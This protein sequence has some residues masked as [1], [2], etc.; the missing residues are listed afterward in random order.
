MTAYG[1]TS[2]PTGRYRRSGLAQRARRTVL[3]Q[4][5]LTAALCLCG[6]L[7]LW[8]APSKALAQPDNP[9]FVDQ[10]PRAWELLCRARDQAP[11]NPGE[12]VRLYQELLDDYSLK[13]VPAD[14]SQQDRFVATRGPVLSDLSSNP[15]LLQRYRAMEKAEAQ[16]MLEAGELERLAIT[17]S[18]TE[19]G[20]E[21]LLRLAQEDLE[22]AR[23]HSANRRLAEALAHP[24]LIGRRAAHAWYMVGLAAHC[25]ADLTRTK[26]AL[27]ALTDLDDAG[28]QLHGQLQ[29][30]CQKPIASRIAEGASSVQPEATIEPGEPVGQAIWTVELTDALQQRLSAGPTGTAFSTGLAPGQV[31]GELLTAS[32]TV[33]GSLAYINQG[34]TILALDRSTGREAWRHVDRP[35]S[36]VIDRDTE[37]VMDVN[38]IAVSGGSLVTLTGHAYG[39]LRSSEGHVLCLDSATGDVRWATILNRIGGIDDHEGL[40]PHGAPIIAEGIVYLAARKV[41]EQHLS[42]CYVVALDL[43]DGRLRWS[44]H[45]ASAGGLRARTY[46]RFSLLTF[47]RGDLYVATPLGAVAR[48]DGS[49]GRMQWLQRYRVPLN[50]DIPLNV[51]GPWTSPA[52][53]VTA[54][55]VIAIRPDGQ[56]VVVLER[57]TG[58]QVASHP[59][60]PRGTWASPDYLLADDR[61]IFAIGDELRAFD[62]DNLAEPVWRLP[63]P[64]R[65][66]AVAGGTQIGGFVIAGRHQLTHRDLVVPTDRGILLVDKATGQVRHHIA[67]PAA[68]NPLA[69]EGQIILAGADRLQAYMSFERASA[70]LRRR[71]SESPDDPDAALAL[72]ELSMASGDLTV[73]MEAAHIATEAIRS[74]DE[75]AEAAQVQATL[76]NL[77]LRF[78]RRELERSSP[79][80]R[81]LHDLLG[82]VAATDEQRVEHLLAH[83]DWL[84]TS[85]PPQAVERYQQIISD[86]HLALVWRMEDG[87]LQTAAAW[88]ARRIASLVQIHGATIQ[89]PQ[90]RNARQ[91]LD[92]VLA[93]TPG[94]LDALRGIS[95]QY[96]CTDAA[97]EAA[98][99]ASNAHAEQ[100]EHRSTL[101]VLSAL[102]DLVPNRDAPTASRLLGAYLSTCRQFGLN[103]EARLLLRQAVQSLNDPILTG[104]FDAARASD[105]LREFERSHAPQRLPHVGAQQGLGIAI[106][107][108]LVPRHP[109]APA[110]SPPDRALLASDGTVRLVTSASLTGQWSNFIDS[111]SPQVLRFTDR[112]VLLWL[113][114]DPQDPRAVML[115]A[116]DG[117]QRWT[118]PRLSDHLDDPVGDLARLRGT[119]DQMPNGDPF[120]P[121]EIIPS[122]NDDLLVLIRRTG[123]AIA[124]DLRE[125]SAPLWAQTRVLDQVYWTDLQD[126]TLVMAGRARS[127]DSTAGRGELKPT[128]VVL[129][130]LT[131]RIIHRAEPRGESDVLWMCFGPLGAL[132]YATSQ[133]IES[134]DLNSG[135][136][137]WMNVQPAALNT[138]RAWSAGGLVFFQDAVSSLR[139]LASGQPLVSDPLPTPQHGQ[140]DPLELQT[141]QIDRGRVA[142]LYAQRVVMYDEQGSVT[143][144][145]YITDERNY[146]WLLP[147]EDRL[148]LV[149]R[150]RTEQVE[151]PDDTG[152][153]TLRTYRVYALSGNGR[154]LG[155]ATE[156]QPLPRR[157]LDAVLIDDWL[158]LS[159][160]SETIAFPLPRDR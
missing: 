102:I 59:C 68:G 110:A 159:T 16:R 19:P 9:I 55:H 33:A 42:S 86:R 52:P 71:L 130:A 66:T 58:R 127:A 97:V 32:P 49:T 137:R 3:K 26:D 132:S 73:T 96:H 51:P 23:F 76:F 57:D 103:E 36:S 152:R 90:E 153:R 38:Y 138:T 75:A 41:T 105:L 125:G 111:D 80:I 37:L 121:D 18:L 119:W 40:F 72:M 8:I 21:A 82:L 98:I 64:D 69:I 45:I 120:N 84:S 24:D 147:A 135:C 92:L 25:V 14:D 157:L 28:R 27:S 48:L 1:P 35:P 34:H 56:R 123:A 63:V 44:Q 6:A 22:S 146:R 78:A 126:R 31:Q 101:A 83:A 107:G 70:M 7:T 113:D 133:G 112:D 30:L 10:S 118:T 134:L 12:S 77:L 39:A 117:S 65:P 148:L 50:P 99:L 15:P 74:M 91:T 81:E 136:V 100:G 160:A 4:L 109:R 89:A 115:N 93:E 116:A 54:D 141:L 67:G 46:R 108:A 94:D 87:R 129:D 13:L 95:E 20:L 150:Y 85:D 156:L 5:R 11:D 143:G 114:D 128:L 122:I 61:H 158:L 29:R 144:S 62:L 106:A 47:D 142:A 145:D 43:E 104:V 60:R 149:S 151:M 131:G 154:L 53:I 124:F 88:A 139:R 2:A 155:E 79:Q 17:R 140:W